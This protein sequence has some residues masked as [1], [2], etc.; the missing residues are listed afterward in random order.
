MLD[1][2]LDLTLDLDLVILLLC[3]AQ[4]QEREDEIGRAAAFAYGARAQQADFM[5]LQQAF[6]QQQQQQRVVQQQLIVLHSRG[7]KRTSDEAEL[8]QHHPPVY[9]VEGIISS[10]TVSSLYTEYIERILPLEESDKA[11]KRGAGWRG[12]STVGEKT[13]KSLMVPV[14]KRKGL[15]EA[16][17]LRMEGPPA[18]DAA[19]AC[20]VM[21]LERM[22]AGEGR[23]M[24]MS[25]W[26]DIINAA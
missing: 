4:E 10:S 23:P 12:K 22:H 13:A 14:S 3:C 7:S 11:C 18:L 16:V 15:Y 19:S 2:D 9:T 24:P 6:Q 25:R 8:G 17:R 1:L 26:L 21:E 5:F 20:H